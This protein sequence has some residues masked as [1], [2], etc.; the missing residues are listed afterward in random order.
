MTKT[1]YRDVLATIAALAERYPTTFAVLDNE[2]RPLKIGIATD[3]EATAV[4][5]D[6]QCLRQAL[7]HYCAAEEMTAA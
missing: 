7:A 2:R 4:D 1:K 6:R 3:I 5:T